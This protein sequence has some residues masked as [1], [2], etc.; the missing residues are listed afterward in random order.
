MVT[1]FIYDSLKR[2]TKILVRPDSNYVTKFLYNGTE[3]LPYMKVIDTSEVIESRTFYTYSTNG[4]LLKDSTLSKTFGLSG[5]L[6]ILA[7]TIK[8]YIM[9]GDKIYESIRYERL[10]SHPSKSI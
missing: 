2:V 1:S 9:S 3:R 10:I 8:K 7:T 5:Q 6:N 4:Q